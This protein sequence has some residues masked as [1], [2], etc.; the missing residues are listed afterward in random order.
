MH[1]LQVS[2]HALI[3]T[4]LSIDRNP[5]PAAPAVAL[6]PQLPLPP[7]R[8]SPHLISRT[9]K[10]RPANLIFRGGSR[11]AAPRPLAA[12]DG[13][14]PAAVTPATPA[15]AQVTPATRATPTP[16]PAARNQVGNL[17]NKLKNF[18]TGQKKKK[19]KKKSP[20]QKLSGARRMLAWIAPVSS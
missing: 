15:A 19:K 10:V 12:A 4:Q 14:G 7:T 1:R 16:T 20:W 18:V 6:H 3:A 5:E 2:C 9:T 13:A 8:G 11:P 17:W